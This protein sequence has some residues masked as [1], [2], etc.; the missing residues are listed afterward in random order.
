MRHQ[1]QTCTKKNTRKEK[2]QNREKDLD[3]GLG[4]AVRVT[5]GEE[6]G[7]YLRNRSPALE[8]T[9]ATQRQKARPD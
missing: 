6:K 9:R 1:Q 8:K 4:L 2:D 7:S 3:I 5:N